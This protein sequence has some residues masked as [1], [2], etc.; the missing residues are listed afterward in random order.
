MG[1]VVQRGTRMTMVDGSNPKVASL[2]AKDLKLVWWRQDPKAEGGCYEEVHQ[3]T[4]SPTQVKGGFAAWQEVIHANLFYQRVIEDK[5]LIKKP[6]LRRLERSQVKRAKRR[7][8]LW[9]KRGPL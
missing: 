9:A 2:L 4:L 3:N 6:E 8:E 7:S 5:D 1:A